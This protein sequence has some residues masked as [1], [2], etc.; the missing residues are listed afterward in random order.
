MRQIGANT[1][2]IQN[3]L[4]NLKQGYS[5]KTAIRQACCATASALNLLR[6]HLVFLLDPHQR[7]PLL[8]SMV[9]KPLP[10]KCFAIIHAT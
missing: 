8:L 1:Q 2:P 7:L 5:L 3:F 9:A 10:A 4:C 6:P